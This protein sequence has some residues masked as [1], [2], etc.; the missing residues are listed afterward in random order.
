MCSALTFLFGCYVPRALLAKAARPFLHPSALLPRVGGEHPS[1]RPSH[2]AA[3]PHGVAP[4]SPRP[5][6]LRGLPGVWAAVKYVCHMPGEERDLS[7]VS[8]HAR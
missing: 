8:T 4:P 6:E 5:A 2:G 3:P 7:L 1:L